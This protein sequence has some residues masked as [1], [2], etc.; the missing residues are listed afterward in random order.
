[1]KS[2]EFTV[3]GEPK[4]KGRPRFRR[5]GNYVQTYTPTETA[6]YENLV[7]M[8]YREEYPNF[9]FAPDVP[10]GMRADIYLPIPKSVSKKKREQMIAG[11]IRPLKKPD[12]SNVLKSIEDGLNKV[13]YAD[14][15]QIVCT[16]ANRYYSDV[17]RV[18]VQIWEMADFKSE[19]LK[20]D[21]LKIGD[22]VL[23]TRCADCI[24][25]DSNLYCAKAGWWVA[26]DDFC[27]KG[28]RREDDE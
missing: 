1:M 21:D 5:V 7:R 9:T 11:A 25:A 23:V 24:H 26:P 6:N 28:E 2:V 18:V 15:T 27:S 4:A 10:L 12:T 19:V 8:V 13:A 3:Y 16:I 17:P 22:F 20:C 14:D